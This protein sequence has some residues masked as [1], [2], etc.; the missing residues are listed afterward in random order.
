MNKYNAIIEKANRV[1]AEENGSIRMK[2]MDKEAKRLIKE[3][4]KQRKKEKAAKEEK[5][6]EDKIKEKE[7]EIETELAKQKQTTSEPA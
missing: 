1:Y 3:D 4:F 5:E 7:R 6:K 2:M